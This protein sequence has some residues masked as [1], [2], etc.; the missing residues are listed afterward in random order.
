[1]QMGRERA[2]SSSNHQSLAGLPIQ[3]QHVRPL[4]PEHAKAG[5]GINAGFNNPRGSC[6]GNQSDRSENAAPKAGQTA[7]VKDRRKRKR[8]TVHNTT[9]RA[10]S[11]VGTYV[12]SASG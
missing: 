10:S 1:M 6:S 9:R 3:A 4:P 7:I 11:S 2:G 12:T 5:A 8:L